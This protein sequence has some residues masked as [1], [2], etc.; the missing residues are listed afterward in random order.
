MNKVNQFDRAGA[1]KGRATLAAIVAAA[2]AWATSAGVAAAQATEVCVECAEPE[3]TYVCQIEKSEKVASF[4]AGLQ[5]LQ[6]LCVSELARIGPHARC[7][8]R[9]NADNCLGTIHTVSIAEARRA[10]SGALAP[11]APTE[12]A[13]EKPQGGS[14]PVPGKAT[15]RPQA[16][17]AVQPTPLQPTPVPSDKS[18]P[19]RTMQ[20]LAER[21]LDASGKQ[22][23]DAGDAVTTGVSKT[24]KCIVT[25]F[26]KC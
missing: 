20:E 19:P 4:R 23:K 16:V 9:R 24:W 15:G 26:Q 21:T 12:P 6:Y 13:A 5:A 18:Q 14:G 11:D 2:I 17:T 25:L 3:K 7:K 8:A 22:A 1:P 10:L